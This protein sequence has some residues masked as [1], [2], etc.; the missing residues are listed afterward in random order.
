MFLPVCVHTLALCYYHSIREQPPCLQAKWKIQSVTLFVVQHNVSGKKALEGTE[1]AQILRSLSLWL[2]LFL[3]LSASL[4]VRVSTSV[5]RQ[6]CCLS[7]HSNPDWM[8][9][10]A[11]K[12]HTH[13]HSSWGKH[14]TSWLSG[15]E[16][17]GHDNYL[18]DIWPWGWN[19][20]KRQWWRA[21][22]EHDCLWRTVTFCVDP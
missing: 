22:G 13:T 12:T 17:K 5:P 6:Q 11:K 14:C 2:L 9:D 18:R 4:L 15:A 8:T 3:A 21:Q 19:V 1:L 20:T 10:C 7:Q 16:L